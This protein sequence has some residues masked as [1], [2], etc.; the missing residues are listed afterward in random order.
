[1]SCTELERFTSITATEDHGGRP[2]ETLALETDD[3]QANPSQ[4]EDDET[5]YPS[6][7]KL[8][9]ILAALM[10]LNISV[11][12]DTSIVAITIPTLTDEFRSIAD[13]AWYATSLRL[14]LCSFLF[15]FGKAYTLFK[16]KPL[17]VSSVAVY[18]IGN[19]LC[20]FAP[21]SSAFIAGRAITG[22]GC[23]GILGG[24]F[25][26]LT[27]SFPLRQ[28]PLV[29]G[30]AGGVETL[31]SLAAPLLGGALID[32]WT[33]RACYGINIPLGVSG[34]LVI[35]FFL[36]VP[37][38]PNYDLPIKERLQRLDLFGTAVFVPALTCLLLAL[39]LG[40]TTFGWADPRT[41]VCF[42]LFGVLLTLFGWLEYRYQDRATLPLPIL[43][44]RSILAGAWFAS[45]C[46]AT[47]AVVEYYMSIYFQGV[48]GTSATRAGIYA[49]PMIG[50]MSVAAVA[51]GAAT[52]WLGYY[53]PYLYMT[54]LVAPLA[55]GFLT[56][57]N[58]DTD[59][60][61]IL[62]LLG[63]LGFAVGGGLMV[64]QYA[65][66]TVLSPQEVSIGYCIVQFGSQLG[67]VIY[68]SASAALF[69]NRLKVEIQA[70]A[71]GTDVLALQNG[72]LSDIRNVIG[73]DRLGQ[74]LLGY[75][76]AVSQTLY[77]PL[78]LTCLTIFGS[79]A[80][81]WRSVKEKK[82]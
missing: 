8:F 4:N 22:L 7:R 53:V 15:L 46:N 23:A 45:C 72:G 17:F 39:E 13:I 78:A 34:L 79:L 41:I 20:T 16:I 42:V 75:D 62:G 77:L 69:R 63:L 60:A 38:H 36:D 48:R 44:N 76:A 59:L 55:T 6:G 82:A 49:L 74:V 64:P 73:G 33:W 61:E 29:G 2:R 50:G 54:T 30:I 32:G 56:Q 25:T 70:H 71:P 3:E 24:M 18:Q 26:I 12:L 5:K 37:H 65:A 35:Y 66:Q 43:R 28:R 81:E 67:P 40:G 31:A 14:V 51:T 80:M 21:T 58:L 10:I 47:L 52:S 1:M 9:A 11:G 27:R 68:L 19:I 57:L